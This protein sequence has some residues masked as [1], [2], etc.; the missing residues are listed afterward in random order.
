[1]PSAEGSE[2]RVARSSR[3]VARVCRARRITLP[4]VAALAAGTVLPLL[5]SPVRVATLGGESRLLLDSTNLLVYP[6]LAPRLAQADVELFDDW[7]GV[8]VPFGRRQ[9]AGL[10]INRP[11]RAGGRLAAYLAGTGSR[12][13]RSLEPRPWLD[14]VYGI[15]LGRGSS[16][17]AGLRFVYDLRERAGDR[18]SAS[19]WEGKVGLSLG[20]ANRSL[21]GA[22]ALARV[23]LEDRVAKASRKQTDGTGYALDLRGRW[24]SGSGVLLLPSLTWDRARYGLSPERREV[25]FAQAALG[26][27]ARPVPSV[28]GLLGIAVSR[29]VERLIPGPGAGAA[30]RRLSLLPAVIAGGEIQAASLLLRLGLRHETEMT[31]VRDGAVRDRAFDTHLVS[32]VGLGFEFGPLAVDGLLEKDFLRDGPHF[33]GGSRRGGGLLSTMSI[34]YRFYR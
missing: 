2:D 18:A 15:G 31:E 27:N 22:L 23:A 12:L 14:A 7:A 29:D 24:A 21:D 32:D 13:L 1:M 4:L 17:G 5:A 34:L 28:L 26:L 19:R 16:V 20:G 11:D 6:A 9:A 25:T 33:I 10:F 3:S 30:Q 8:V